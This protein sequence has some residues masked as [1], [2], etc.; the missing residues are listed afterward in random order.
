MHFICGP[1]GY[2]EKLKIKNIDRNP[3]FNSIF[4]KLHIQHNKLGSKI[5]TTKDNL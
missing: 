4:K 1:I 5:A 2:F 3:I